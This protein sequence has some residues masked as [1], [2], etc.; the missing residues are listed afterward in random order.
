VGKI[1]KTM[2]KDLFSNLGVK[3]MIWLM[4]WKSSFQK[5]NLKVRNQALLLNLGEPK[6][7]SLTNW[8]SN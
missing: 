7:L 6:T 2:R 5:R 4:N 1:V 3:K 8:N